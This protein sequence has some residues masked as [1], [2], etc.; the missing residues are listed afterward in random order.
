MIVA[1]ILEFLY[2]FLID[3]KHIKDINYEIKIQCIR[4]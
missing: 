4:K 1:K 2:I 3:S